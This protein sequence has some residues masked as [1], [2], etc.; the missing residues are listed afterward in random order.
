MEEH[1]TPC[2]LAL[3]PCTRPAIS[4][5]SIPYQ[6]MSC[7]S[8]SLVHSFTSTGKYPI[9]SVKM[10]A[11]ICRESEKFIN[12]QATFSSIHERALESA[13]GGISV[14]ESLAS[15]AVKVRAPLLII[16]LQL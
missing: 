1:Q 11:D 12:Y 4:A 13:N 14:A 3:T 16:V 15:S 9:E 5:H 6:G 2:D 10:M 7:V 8:P